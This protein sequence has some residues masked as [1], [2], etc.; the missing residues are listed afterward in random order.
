MAF[1]CAFFSTVVEMLFG[2]G[3]EGEERQDEEGIEELHVVS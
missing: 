2:F 3:R 1:S